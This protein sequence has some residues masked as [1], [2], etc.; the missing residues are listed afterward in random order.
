RSSAVEEDGCA[1]AGPGGLV[2]ER[3]RV[4]IVRRRAGV[5]DPFAQQR[6]AADHVDRGARLVL[7][8]EVAPDGIAR[9]ELPERLQGERDE[10]PRPEALVI[11]RAVLDVD[12][13]AGA[14]LPRVL[15]ERRLEPA[16]T[17]SAALEPGRRELRHRR[18]D[19][20]RIDVGRAEDFERAR[21]PAP[22]GERR[23]LEH[24]RAGE[25]ARHA[26]ARRVRAR[27]DPRALPERP[28]EAGCA[29][30]SPALHGDDLRIDVETEPLD[31]P[32][33]E[34]AE[35]EAVPHRQR[36]GADEALPPVA[37]PEALDR[38]ADR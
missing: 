7:V 13:E 25:A 15:L 8:R 35:R 18:E 9:P 11:V 36:T 20:A 2:R 10:P 31:E 28:A 32:A 3:E 27:V 23:P 19:R 38:T 4:E 14:E 21:R 17:E 24:H 29:G 5:V 6:P 16:R 1:L 30:G 34:L 22:L 26:D 12:L 37:Q 33:R